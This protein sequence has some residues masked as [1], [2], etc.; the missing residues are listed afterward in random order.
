M[1]KITRKHF[2]NKNK[3]NKT[4]KYKGG[5]EISDRQG[6]FDII[7]NK[8]SN[9]T[10]SAVSSVADA[11]LKI[12]GLER[13]E[14]KEESKNLEETTKNIANDI[15]E[16]TS[17]IASDVSNVADKTS[18]ALIENV[19]E[20]LGSDAVNETAKQAAQDTADITTE[21][22][23]NFNET[24][25]NPEVKQEVKE[26]LDNAGE[27]ASVAVDALEEPVQKAV[28]VT[29]EAAQKATSAAVSGAI[30]VGT[31]AMAAVPFWGA[32]I[33]LGKMVNDGSRAAS[34]IVEAG[35][36]AVEVASD[37]FID[38]KDNFEKGLKELEEK[39]KLSHKIA[40]RTTES[41]NQFENPNLLQK[42][43]RKTK[44]R[45]IKRKLKSK[46]VR[47]AI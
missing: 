21:L 2:K 18:A 1:G 19:N 36:E 29:A 7:G 16:T 33:D 27:I 5:S 15:S 13:I 46:R 17:N 45:L 42:G 32:I 24:I 22:L 38:T 12:V 25:N 11:S 20:V 34:A 3:K 37:A 44:R 28:D 8:I 26:A 40:N 23:D 4:L 30:K 14:D 35:S 9:V 39:K 31:D 47:F 10:S 43:G 6:V 41:I